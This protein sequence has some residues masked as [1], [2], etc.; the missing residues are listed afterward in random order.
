M[1]PEALEYAA[2]CLRATYAQLVAEPFNV[3][4]RDL[5]RLT[6][7]QIAE[8]YMHRRTDKGEIVRPDPP[9]PP[10]PERGSEEEKAA[11]FALCASLGFPEDDARDEWARKRG[12]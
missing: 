11:F 7:R 3:P 12:A 8:V 1:T 2:A 9:A 10:P 6:D 4:A 5:A